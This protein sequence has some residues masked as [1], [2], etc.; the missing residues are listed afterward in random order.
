MHSSLMPVQRAG[1]G[2]QVVRHLR[3]AIVQGDLAVGTHLVE[4]ALAGQFGVSRG[5][6]RDA[7]RQLEGEGL[8]RTRRR[9]AFVVGIDSDDI[10]ELY[11]LRGAVESL[12]ARLA[13]GRP[14]VD[15]QASERLVQQMHDKAAAGAAEAF[16][17]ADIAF[18]SLI[19]ENSGHR[20]LLDVWRQYEAIL[21]SLLRRTVLLS[22]DLAE[23]AA[24]H[25]ILLNLLTSGSPDEMLT[26]LTDHLEGSRRRM[27]H[28]Y[29]SSR[30]DE[31]SALP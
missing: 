23:S 16:A 12:A 27:L 4:D 28:A 10:D 26:E 17:E 22:I 8:V 21:A 24:K 30:T 1:L 11:S 9:G 6:V 20:R 5:P 19:Y 2:E 31:N 25:E 3:E 13:M 29:H 14:E 7:L 15:W 18:H